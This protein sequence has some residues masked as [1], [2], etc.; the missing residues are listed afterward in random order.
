[1][2]TR[3]SHPDPLP[4][5]TLV[6]AAA[7]V[8][9]SGAAFTKEEADTITE[10]L[11]SG[12]PT[13]D[14]RYRYE[15]VDQETF[16]KDAEASTVR[17]RLGYETGTYRGLFAFAELEGIKSVGSDR[18]DSTSNGRD[19]FPAV[20]DPEGSEVNQAY[21]AYEGLKKTVI[22]AG[23]QRIKLDNDRFIG[24]VGFRQNEQTFDALSVVSEIW[25]NTKL[26]VAHVNNVNRIF[27]EDHSDAARADLST[28]TQ[29]LHVAHAFPVGTL[30][31]YAHWLD[32]TEA[33]AASHRNVGVRFTGSHDLSD[34]MKLL[35]TGE[36]ADQSDYKDAPSTVDAGYRLA[37]LGLN[38][39]KI[40]FKAGYEVLEGD[41]VYGFATPFATLHAHNGW[42][43]QFLNTPAEGIEDLY[44][45]VT[46]NVRNWKLLGVYHDFSENEGSADHGDE[47]G[48]LVARTFKK[49]YGVSF[50]YATYSA[51]THSVDTDKFWITFELKR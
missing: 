36:L 18:Y 33:P 8:L 28:S 34:G 49:I 12:K 26:T 4:R 51:D 32:L 37:E 5:L 21:L 10:A 11:K 19:D 27:G 29:I 23:R 2:E 42:T 17:L 44:F 38:V 16:E 47:F 35:Y 46:G 13:V 45:L 6:I 25:K 41:G 24:N 9:A 40:T 48:F 3:N 14:V 43:D 20:V 15:G 22:K 50:K 31:G 39:K 7:M 30:T 1:M